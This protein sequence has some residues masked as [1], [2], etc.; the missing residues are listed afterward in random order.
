MLDVNSNAALQVDSKAASSKMRWSAG[1][2]IRNVRYARR[3]IFS[4][5]FAENIC[6]IQIGDLLLNDFAIGIRGNDVNIFLRNEAREAIYGRLNQ[7]FAC[8]QDIK[9][10]F[11]IVRP[12][13]GPKAASYSS[14]HNGHIMVWVHGKKIR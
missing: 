11:R 2:Q 13:H 5:W 8:I 14:G 1:A 12:T 7:G 9:E 3:C 6:R 4:G 10:L